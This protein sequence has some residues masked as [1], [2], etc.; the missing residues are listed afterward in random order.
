MKKIASFIYLLYWSHTICFAQK[1]DIKSFLVLE[2]TSNHY[3]T[4]NNY[5]LKDTNGI[6]YQAGYGI[7]QTYKQTRFG[8]PALGISKYNDSHTKYTEWLISNIHY[9]ST[10]FSIIMANKIDTIG[11]SVPISG[12]KLFNISGALMYSKNFNVLKPDQKLGLWLGGGLQLWN[13]WSTWRPATSIT[14]PT[15]QYNAQLNAVFLPRI[16]YKISKKI[17]AEV[18]IPIYITPL[19]LNF[20]DQQNPTSSIYQQ[21]KTDVS[22]SFVPRYNTMRI[23]LSIKI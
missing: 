23:G 11:T 4:E 5:L 18:H 2:K 12:G 20:I 3:F 8:M 7:N 17:S 9:S 6:V 16:S 14:F 13:E 21:R 22:T 10:L 15:K 1:I 19:A